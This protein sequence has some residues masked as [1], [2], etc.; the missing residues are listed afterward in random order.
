VRPTCLWFATPSIAAYDEARV[1]IDRLSDTA[2][3][4]KIERET[5]RK[6]L[7]EVEEIAA[8]RADV[9]DGVPDAW[10]RVLVIVREA[11]VPRK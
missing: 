2:L 3:S 7:I 1:A 8:D 5:M 9:D 4:I 11:L 6:A 10:M